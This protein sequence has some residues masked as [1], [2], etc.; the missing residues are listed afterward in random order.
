MTAHFFNLKIQ[1]MGKSLLDYYKEILK[2]VSFDQQ[3]FNKELQK[4]QRSIEKA[5]NDQLLSWLEE[6]GLN[7]NMI[8][9][10]IPTKKFG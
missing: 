4:A 9:V 8:P 5:E 1:R 6:Q 3:L 7:S 2:K 10:K